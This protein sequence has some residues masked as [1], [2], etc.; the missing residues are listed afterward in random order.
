[1]SRASTKKQE[2]Q[3]QKEVAPVKKEEDDLRKTLKLEQVKAN[4]YLNRLKYLQAD[5]ENFKK[6]TQKE[7]TE[8]AKY[9]NLNLIS[10]LLPI[11]DEFEYAIEAGKQSDNKKGITKGVEMILK[12]L[13]EVLRKQGLCKIDAIGQLLDPTKHEAIIKVPTKDYKEGTIIE[14]VRKGFIFKAKVIRPSL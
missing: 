11:V 3:V 1:M 4:E 5:F 13:Y 14:E 7:M 6:R 12:K 10:E 8:V 9:S 2:P